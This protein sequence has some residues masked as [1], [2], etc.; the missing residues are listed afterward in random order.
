MPHSHLDFHLR[1]T[2][3]TS[4]RPQLA[5]VTF[6]ANAIGEFSLL[7]NLA[8]G[9][10]LGAHLFGGH[11]FTFIYLPFHFVQLLF[12]LAEIEN[13]IREH[14]KYQSKSSPISDSGIEIWKP[15]LTGFVDV[16]SVSHL[17]EN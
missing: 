2:T 13:V 3:A 7:A 14:K 1:S 11:F 15:H 5:I 9:V 6:V 16:E 4:T 12:I 8:N 17:L 10:V